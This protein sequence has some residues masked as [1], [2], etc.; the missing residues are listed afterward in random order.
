MKHFLNSLLL[1]LVVQLPCW[2]AENPVEVGN[3]RWGRDYGQA[4]QRSAAT[5]RPVLLLF[6]EV[7]G[8]L[9][10]Q[11]FGK[12]V[13]RQPLLVE[14]IEDEFEPLLIYNNW[15]GMDERIRRLFAEPAWN[16]QVIRFLD[17]SGKDII[18][19]K[20]RVWSVAGVAG[21]ME[22]ALQAHRRP[23]PSYLRLL[24]MEH[25]SE[26]LQIA[27]FAMPCFWLGE[28]VLGQLDGVVSTEA[29]W[30]DSRE[31][32]KVVFHR[33]QI[34]LAR[35]IGQAQQRLPLSGVYLPP[36]A[37]KSWAGQVTGVLDQRYQ[38]AKGLDQKRQLIN[39]PAVLKVPGL[40]AMQMTK[41]NAFWP[42]DQAQALGWLSPRQRHVWFELQRKR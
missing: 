32:T 33:Q 17:S 31:V 19:R 25:D 7:P 2:A 39:E 9:G 1:L 30:L 11:D 12:T 3:V 8:C 10:C 15:G 27:A 29:G 34:S 38:P 24:A 13:L 16:F 21:R 23:V 35:L 41:L 6:Q 20:D 40:T 37:M 26:E 4:L 5:G 36:A 18:E 28:M 22:A 42:V 14:A